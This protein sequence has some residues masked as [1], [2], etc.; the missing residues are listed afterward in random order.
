MFF[1]TVND[2]TLGVS[3]N[4]PSIYDEYQKRAKLVELMSNDDTNAESLCYLS[5][6]KGA[7]WPFLM[8]VQRYFP[9]PESGFHPGILL[10][11]ETPLL[12]IGAGKRLSAYTW[13]PPE[14]LWE[15]SVMGGFWGWER[16]KHLII[17]SAEIEMAA[18]DIS[19]KKLWT[20][21]VEPPWDYSIEGDTIHLNVMG[22]LSVFSL[23][24]GPTP[25]FRAI[26]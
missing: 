8:V 7:D 11:P 21:P 15:E 26:I 19:G 4:F 6:A 23:E 16:Y 13:D 18:W 10:I 24:H 2:Y 14:K 25:P 12:L 9:G 17:L 3:D 5:V 1:V 20:A 22:Q